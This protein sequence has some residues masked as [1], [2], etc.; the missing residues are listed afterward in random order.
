[1]PWKYG[2]P[3]AHMPHNIIRTMEYVLSSFRGCLVQG[4]QCMGRYPPSFSKDLAG[5]GA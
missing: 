2:S 1:M 4:R 5:G 3:E